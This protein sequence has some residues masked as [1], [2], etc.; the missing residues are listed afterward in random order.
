MEASQKRMDVQ[1]PHVPFSS[2][3]PKDF[4]SEKTQL[5]DFC[6]GFAV[7]PVGTKKHQQQPGFLP[8]LVLLRSQRHHR[9]KGGSTPWR[10][11]IFFWN[12]WGIWKWPWPKGGG[13]RGCFFLGGIFWKGNLENFLTGK[14]EDVFPHNACYL[15]SSHLFCLPLFTS[16]YFQTHPRVPSFL[17]VLFFGWAKSHQKWLA[18]D[19][20]H[21]K[22]CG[23]SSFEVPKSDV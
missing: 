11:R 10:R 15:D 14:Y 13:G 8:C 12:E 5:G 20:K 3:P 18:V 17:R 21:H 2:G 16:C 1:L 6:F 22:T 7:F 19:L 9:D 23:L 4:L